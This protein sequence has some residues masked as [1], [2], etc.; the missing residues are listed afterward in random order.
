MRN[1]LAAEIVVDVTTLLD[2]DDAEL[3]SVVPLGVEGPSVAPAGAKEGGSA[4][5]LH[6]MDPLV[7][8]LEFVVLVGVMPQ[9]SSSFS[10]ECCKPQRL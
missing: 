8:K 4:V 9:N 2:F 3:D 5:T 6:P 7:S 10:A 1:T